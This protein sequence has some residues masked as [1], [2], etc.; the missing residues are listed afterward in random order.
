MYVFDATPLIY[1]AKAGR[2]SVLSDL[3][4]KREI[5]RS[6]YEETVETGLDAGHPDARRIE[7][8][9]ESETFAVRPAP[10]TALFHRLEANPRLSDADAAV[11]A[12]AADESGIAIM[13][14]AYGRKVAETEAIPTRGTAFLLLQLVA[15]GHLTGSEAKAIVDEIVSAGWYCSTELYTKVV[16]KF[17]Q[18]ESG[19]A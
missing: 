14:E 15:N 1:L 13:D 19:D 18:L 2:L 10:E 17:E 5:P 11:L 9:V 3:P 16:K 12:L 6:V 7:Q 8:H 4:D